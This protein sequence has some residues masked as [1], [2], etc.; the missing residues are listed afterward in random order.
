MRWVWGVLALGA[1]A[2][3]KPELCTED[4]CELGETCII[5]TFIDGD[6]SDRACVP[7]PT[8]C[9]ELVQCQAIGSV[10]TAC[11]NA[12][13]TQCLPGF[14]LDEG[15]GCNSVD[16]VDVNLVRCMQPP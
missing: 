14:T 3:G 16:N 10:S 4:P 13:L 11:Q 1:T 9:P 7:T 12:L 8:E 5:Q 6:D 2:C 15:M